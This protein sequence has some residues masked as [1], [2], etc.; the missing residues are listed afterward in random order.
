MTEIR[1]SL[2][3]IMWENVGIVRNRKE[4]T[5]ALKRLRAWERMIKGRAPDRNAFELTNMLAVST[6][7]TRSALQREGSVGAHFRTDFPT[8][9][10]NWRTRTVISG[11]RRL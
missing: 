8:K 11:S 4:L 3:K 9:G 2:K 7:I 5:G 10:K 6:L 1:S